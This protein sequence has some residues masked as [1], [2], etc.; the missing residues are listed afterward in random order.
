M[1]APS[2]LLRLAVT[3]ASLTAVAAPLAA[4]AQVSVGIQIGLPVAPPMVVIQPGVQVVEDY[5]EE[6]FF[7]GGWYWAR[8]GPQ[9]YRA[10]QPGVTF[11]PVQP[12]YVPATLVRIPPGHYKHWRHHEEREA[13]REAKAERKY[14]K[15]QAK[16]EKHHGNENGHGNHGN[17]HGHDRD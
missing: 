13:R 2:R 17:G 5:H 14:W 15:E 11:M 4:R 16:A 12:R 7:T 3:I 9:W 1:I 8:R 6:V 10:R